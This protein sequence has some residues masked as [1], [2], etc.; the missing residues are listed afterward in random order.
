MVCTY[1]QD[2]KSEK[3]NNDELNIILKRW[4]ANI[5][6]HIFHLEF[7]IM[8]AGDKFIFQVIFL[9]FF[10]NL[11]QK[12]YQK[13]QTILHAFPHSINVDS[14]SG[15]IASCFAYCHLIPAT[16]IAG[17]HYFEQYYLL[18]EN[19]TKLFVTLRELV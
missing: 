2:T 13:I 18:G 15:S 9:D 5:S 19:T 12:R 10:S 7:V 1:P 8:T 4:L 16:F 3:R 11:L 14:V 17:W 6:G